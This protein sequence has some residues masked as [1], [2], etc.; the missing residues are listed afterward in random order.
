MK[1]TS[2]LIVI[3]LLLCYG[4][5]GMLDPDEP[6]TLVPKTVIE[7]PTLPR[8]AI[9]G[10]VL[11]A[12]TFGDTSDTI[13][14]VVVIFLHGGPGRDYRSLLKLQ[15]LAADGYFLVFFDQRGS[16]LSK[17]HDEENI[18]MDTYLEDLN[19]IIDLYGNSSTRHV[20]LFGHGWGA[21]YATAYINKYPDKID[22][23]IFSEPYPFT[24]AH[25]EEIKDDLYSTGLSLKWYNDYVWNSLFISADSHE[26]KDY[27]FL[28]E[29]KD[30]QPN[31]TEGVDNPRP[32]WRLGAVA[33]KAINES[34]Q[35]SDGKY[36]F[37]FTT[38][39]HSFDKNV[40]FIRGSLNKVL[41]LDHH[42]KLS[43]YYP[44]TNLITVINVGHDLIWINPEAIIDAIRSY[45]WGVEPMK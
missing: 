16:G 29:L 22:G 11:H 26:R 31:L 1:L 39:L 43:D 12:E 38:N 19:Q 6:G 5:S 23:A 18:S 45:I 17:R 34:L 14:N 32:V 30:S 8:I 41:D 4:C 33:H 24:G 25:L 2:L 13:E 10:T 35:G 44:S 7:D 20:V 42:L 36:N 15:T 21:T 3:V 27:Q 28:F 9:N 37:D 40:I